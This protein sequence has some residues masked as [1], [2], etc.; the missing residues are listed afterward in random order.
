MYH[1]WRRESQLRNP[2]SRS[3]RGDHEQRRK[4]KRKCIWLCR[5]CGRWS[6]KRSWLTLGL[7]RTKLP[8]PLAPMSITK[9]TLDDPMFSSHP[10]TPHPAPT[11]PARTSFVPKCRCPASTEAKWATAW[12]NPPSS[13][14]TIRITLQV[15]TTK[16]LKVFRG[17]KTEWRYSASTKRSRIQI[18]H[19]VV[20]I[21]ISHKITSDH[22]WKQWPGKSLSSIKLSKKNEVAG[23]MSI[24]SHQ[25]AAQDW[26][27]MD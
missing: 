12:A 18:L 3:R 4:L 9:C 8:K 6:G 2:R 14:Q 1:L 20:I 7:A 16:T 23:M 27:N 5:S 17:P 26:K 19:P 25:N 11:K 24:I 22:K 13:T 21:N 15:Q 10:R